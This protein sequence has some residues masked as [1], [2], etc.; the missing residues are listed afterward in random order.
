MTV[1]HTR[2]YYFYKA[3][4]ILLMIFS[5]DLTNCPDKYRLYMTKSGTVVHTIPIVQAPKL[6]RF[7]IV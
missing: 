1:T 3:L 5:T 4:D 2:L 7:N 6:F